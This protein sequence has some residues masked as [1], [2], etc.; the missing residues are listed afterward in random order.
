LAVGSLNREWY[1]FDRSGKVIIRIPLGP[2]LEASRPSRNGRLLVK[3]GFNFGYK[4][5]AGKWAIPAKYNAEEDF[6]GGFASV[7]DGT[8]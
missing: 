8:K 5:S 1:Y 6:E 3:D 4:N 2:N 7:Q